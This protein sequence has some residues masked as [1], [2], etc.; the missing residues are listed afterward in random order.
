MGKKKGNAKK[1][2]QRPMPTHQDSL[3]RDIDAARIHITDSNAYDGED[4]D[5]IA[6][7]LLAAL[8]ARDKAAAGITEAT[9]AE[10]TSNSLQVP[11]GGESSRVSSLQSGSSEKSAAS[12][13]SPLKSAGEKL[14]HVGER[15]FHHNRSPSGSSSIKS[16]PLSQ[17]P[18]TTSHGEKGSEQGSDVHRRGSIMRIFGHHA[19]S[20]GNDDTGGAEDGGKRKVSR[21][22]ARLVSGGR[23]PVA[24]FGCS[25]G[26]VRGLTHVSHRDLPVHVLGV[27]TAGLASNT[28]SV[29]LG[30]AYR[31]LKGINTD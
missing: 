28:F 18:P 22:K 13:S 8:D 3:R 12:S 30:S 7:Q 26:C 27:I 31:G 20:S 9:E 17:S 16:P 10:S 2:G 15:M 6:D 25:G 19:T 11:D 1:G 14:L 21:Q 29:V 24:V 5:D 4:G 23:R